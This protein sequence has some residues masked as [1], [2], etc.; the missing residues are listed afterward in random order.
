MTHPPIVVR[1]TV[2][3]RAAVIAVV[4]E[5]DIETA[6]ELR[7]AIS[8]C[9]QEHLRTLSLDLSRVSFCDCSG[10][11]VLLRARHLAAE[12]KVRLRLLYPRPQLLALLATSETAKYFA[13]TRP[14]ELPALGSLVRSHP[15]LLT[16]TSLRPPLQRRAV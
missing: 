3:D 8:T 10:L 2:A 6:P 14:S 13:V 16:H 15:P 4:G 5:L 9:L 1:T 7:L 11:N 12:A